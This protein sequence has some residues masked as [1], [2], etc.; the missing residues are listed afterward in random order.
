MKGGV[1][2]VG[3]APAPGAV[4]IG[5]QHV[6]VD[7]QVGGTQGFH[8]LMN[9][10]L[11][12]MWLLSGAFFPLAGAPG[13][14]E[15]VMRVNPM[16]YGMTALRRALYLGDPV[17]YGEDNAEVRELQERYPDFE[18]PA[19]DFTDEGER[20]DLAAWLLSGS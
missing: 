16:T 18:M 6:I 19:Y 8:A 3:G 20:R 7:E 15:W 11:M 10:V 1:L 17:A 12:P 2:V 4:G 14:L 13:W 5:A 9:L